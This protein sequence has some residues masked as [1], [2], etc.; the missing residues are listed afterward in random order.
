M[1][2]VLQEKTDKDVF[3]VFIN[4]FFIQMLDRELSS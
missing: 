1:K 2:I 4:S 3:N